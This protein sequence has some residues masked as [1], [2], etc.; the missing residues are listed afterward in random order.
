MF[1]FRQDGEMSC[2]QHV[3]GEF[4][5]LID[6]QNLPVVSNVTFLCRAQFPGEVFHPLLEHGTHGG[7]W[8]VRDQ[9][10]WSDWM[11]VSQNRNLDKAHFTFVEDCNEFFVPGKRM[12]ALEIREFAA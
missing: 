7:G 8:S 4:H 11:W 12:G 10:E 6:R 9:G 2:H 5:G 1:V 3:A